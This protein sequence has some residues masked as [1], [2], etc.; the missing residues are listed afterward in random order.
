MTQEEKDPRGLKILHI[1]TGR[2]LRGGQQQLFYL[3][4]GLKEKGF[5]QTVA[6]VE[7][8]PV[9][10]RC[11]ELGLETF[12]LPDY[13]PGHLYGA[14]L[15][16]ARVREATFDL[17]H[18]HDGHGH[19][20]SLLASLFLKIPRVATRRVLF[21]AGSRLITWCKYQWGADALIAVSEAVKRVAVFSGIRSQNVRVIFDGVEIPQLPDEARRKSCRERWGIR[22][23]EFA[24]GHVATFSH[25]KG[26]GI[27]AEAVRRLRRQH[28]KLRFLLVGEGPLR[29][30]ARFQDACRECGEN[31]QLLGRLENLD[32][33][34]PALDLFIMP[35]L[36]EGL[37]SSAL[38]A[39]AYGLPVVASRVGGLPEVVVP[40]ETGW[41]VEPNSPE[42]LARVVGATTYDR[43]RLHRMGRRGRQRVESL[44]SCGAMIEKTESLYQELLGRRFP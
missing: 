38:L 7:D 33:Y 24:V 16:R 26:Q 9:E 12:P 37:G 42:I 25:E 40:Q 5:R 41:L 31:L 35:S 11:R 29:R 2:T 23:D 30:D 43:E 3:L 20:V 10:L 15:L 8:S 22:D 19:T 1:D 18:A 13:D 27:V 36:S 17:I 34:F 32:D 6:C 4:R 44:F 21:R 28:P 39:M 14:L